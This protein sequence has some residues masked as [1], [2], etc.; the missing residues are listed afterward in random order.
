MRAPV[1]CL[2]LSLAAAGCESIIGIREYRRP[3]DALPADGAF[4]GAGQPDQAQPESD[5]GQP[6]QCVPNFGTCQRTSDCCGHPAV[7]CFEFAQGNRCSG[8]CES[9][10]AC[11]S[12]CCLFVAGGK[13]ACG[14]AEECSP[15][16]RKEGET[17]DSHDACCGGQAAQ[18]CVFN[19]GEPG[20]CR[21]RCTDDLLCASRCCR[22]VEGG[23]RVCFPSTV[24]CPPR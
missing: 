15:Q 21:P 12:G 23:D 8:P 3:A 1:L 10:A 18:L 22:P 17:C 16:C 19:R 14:R 11:A 13:G 7:G 4:D 5:S 24:P 2:L 6:M 9:N 20:G